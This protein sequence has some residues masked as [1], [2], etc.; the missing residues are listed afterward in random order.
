MG[1]GAF[2]R[3]LFRRSP[4]GGRRRPRGET[5]EQRTARK[6]WDEQIQADHQ[7]RGVTRDHP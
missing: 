4:A 3:R 5:G 1:L 6:Y 2:L 7:R